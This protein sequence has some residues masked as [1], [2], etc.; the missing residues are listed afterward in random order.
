MFTQRKRKNL[1][2]INVLKFWVKKKESDNH[3]VTQVRFTFCIS[4]NESVF[5]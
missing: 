2:K 5:I 3:S 1:N 4:G